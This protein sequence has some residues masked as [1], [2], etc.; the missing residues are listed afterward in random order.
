MIGQHTFAFLQD[1]EKHNRD[2]AWFEGNRNRYEQEL[3]LPMKSLAEAISFP[4]SLILPDTP[5]KP[6]LSRIYNDLRFH[7]DKPIY[8]RHMWL[9]IGVG[10]PSELWFAVGPQG[11]SLGCKIVGPKR[12]DL[13]DFR[14][15]LLG[16]SDRWRQYIHALEMLRN[17]AVEI[18]DGFKNPLFDDIPD[19][20]F[21]LVQAKRVWVVQPRRSSFDAA[22][23]AEAL[24]GLSAMLPAYLFATTPPPKL[25]SRLAE[26][27]D[28]I[29]APFEFIEP[30]WDAVRA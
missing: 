29:I 8:K 24:A 5:V 16:N 22:P 28:L 26:L 21:E 30:I 10:Q 1:L 14:R 23:E 19:D 9:K 7:K 6:R 17:G 27:N 11:W 15:N 18:D 3:L 4:M 2:K 25:R 13:L 20:I 12:N